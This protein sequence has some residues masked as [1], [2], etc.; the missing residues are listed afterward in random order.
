MRH[1]GKVEFVMALRPLYAAPLEIHACVGAVVN[2][3]NEHWVALKAVSGDVWFL[4][5]QEL[6]PSKMTK[7]EYVKFIDKRRAAYP[8]YWAEQMAASSSAPN[9]GDSPVLP[10]ASQETPVDDSMMSAE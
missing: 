3:E 7:D 4:D 10:L 8:I 6:R 5:S 1:A 2:V 9:C